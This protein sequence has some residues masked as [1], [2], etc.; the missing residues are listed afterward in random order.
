MHECWESRRYGKQV[1]CLPRFRKVLIFKK[2]WKWMDIRDTR[3]SEDDTE[4]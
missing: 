3:I 1:R 4:E 2:F